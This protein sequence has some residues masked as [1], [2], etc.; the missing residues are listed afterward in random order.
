MCILSLLTQDRAEIA[1]SG[2]ITN[3][4]LITDGLIFSH[5]PSTARTMAFN[6]TAYKRLSALVNLDKVISRMIA[7][8]MT[9]GLSIALIGQ[10]H[11]PRASAV[12]SP[13][14]IS[15]DSIRYFLP[16]AAL[17]P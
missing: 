5:L 1:R 8:G 3:Q 14:G 15:S 2:I 17:I 13:C 6:C 12:H 11:H 9:Y 7:S 10:A 16:I 4:R